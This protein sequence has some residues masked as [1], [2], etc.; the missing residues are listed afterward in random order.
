MSREERPDAPR[1]DDDARRRTSAVAAIASLYCQWRIMGRELER[2]ARDLWCHDF[3]DGFRALDRVCVSLL[4]TEELM[5]LVS[6]ELAG[7]LPV[8]AQLRATLF[9]ELVPW[10]EEV[11]HELPSAATLMCSFTS[12]AAVWRE[13]AIAS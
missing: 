7:G 5:E 4:V 3:D 12:A 2:L 1:P 10:L 6:S 8:A 9:E 13:V 11:R